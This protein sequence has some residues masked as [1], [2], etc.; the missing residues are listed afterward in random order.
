MNSRPTRRRKLV[1]RSYRPKKKFPANGQ[2]LI[3]KISELDTLL[4]PLQVTINLEASDYAKDLFCRFSMAAQKRVVSSFE[5]FVETIQD[6]IR[7][8]Q[9]PWDSQ[10]LTWAFLQKAGIHP[11]SRLFQS[12]QPDD[13]IEIFNEDFVQIFRSLQFFTHFDLPLFDLLVLD[14]MTILK[15]EAKVEE[16]LFLKLDA[17]LKQNRGVESPKR[18]AQVWSNRFGDCKEQ[19]S[20]DV[21]I[22]GSLLSRGRRPARV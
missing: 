20:I 17:A 8:Q 6:L 3:R 7:R 21:K 22:I 12:F 13:V 16:K 5:V 19:Y 18:L 14:R 2:K 11:H 1:L 4:R 15:S 9:N 10:R